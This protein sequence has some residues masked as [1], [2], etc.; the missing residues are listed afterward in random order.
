MDQDRNRV[1]LTAKKSLLDSTLPIVSKSE[2]VKVGMVTH[3]VV[4]RTY[5]KHIMVEF[6]NNIKAA[7]PHRETGWVPSAVDYYSSLNG[8]SV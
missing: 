5:E 6:Y 3:A 1:S 2:D 7:I 8:S 4:F